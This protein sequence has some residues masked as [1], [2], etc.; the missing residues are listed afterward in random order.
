M[1]PEIS[2][3]LVLMAVGMT[4]VL[5]ALGLVA[6][7]GHLLILAVN[8]YAPPIPLPVFPDEEGIRHPASGAEN[9][10][11]KVAVILAA[12]E[13]VTGGKGTIISV[14]GER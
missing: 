7:L 10:P 6:G 11:A 4:T 9:D 13:V 12:V 2:D 5:L 8:R 14:N 1:R 3:G